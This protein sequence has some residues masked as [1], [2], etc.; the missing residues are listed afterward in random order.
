M[1]NIKKFVTIGLI[2]L[3]IFISIIFISH[4]K[5]YGRWYL[6]NGNDINTDS[7]ISK[8]L[9]SKEYIEI[10][11]GVIEIFNSNDKN[12]SSEMTILGSKMHVGDAV[13]KYDIKN[14]GEYKILVLEL[15]G[16]KNSYI[17][18]KVEDGEKLIYVFD[19]N[20]KFE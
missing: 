2:T 12:S 17:K 5:I 8:Q 15:K 19:N 1:S 10:S 11:K 14:I 9:N 6:Y 18:E 7:S 20:I 4:E 3:V 13:Y 16:Y